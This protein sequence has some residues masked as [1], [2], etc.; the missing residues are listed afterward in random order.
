[1]YDFEF[2]KYSDI[3]NVREDRIA[4]LNTLMIDPSIYWV[5]HEKLHGANFSIW[6]NKD[7]IRYASRQQ[8]VDETFY[9]C[10][11][12]LDNLLPNVIKIQNS[13]KAWGTSGEV[14]T[15]YGEL[16]GDKI[17]KGVLYPQ[18]KHFKAFDI[19]IDGKYIDYEKF[20]H[21]C[22]QYDLPTVPFIQAG[23]LESLL[24]LPVEFLTRLNPIVDNVA[25][26]LVIKPNQVL[27]FPNG[28]R[29]IFKRKAARFVEKNSTKR[30]I[31]NTKNMSS[32]AVNLIKELEPYINTNRLNC[33][34]S[35]LGPVQLED[36][37]KLQGLLIQDC[38]K[39]YEIDTNTDNVKDKFKDDWKAIHKQLCVLTV[40]VVKALF[41]RQFGV[42]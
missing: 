42:V 5:A 24:E 27:F 30:V 38:L 20:Q 4:F 1:M 13:I 3:E 29:I 32:Y 25:E 23:T 26:G 41:N 28:N 14:W 17:Q 19:M 11:T 39:D 36:F 15:I 7:E 9:N 21:I 18:G 33:V 40:P 34:V 37:N 35:K 6:I 10:K 16:F 22:S 12:V 2:K 8:W 31:T